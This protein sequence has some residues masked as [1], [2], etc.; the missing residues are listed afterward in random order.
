MTP[1]CTRFLFVNSVTSLVLNAL[2]LC[3]NDLRPTKSEFPEYRS[4]SFDHHGKCQLHPLHG[5]SL[6]PVTVLPWSPLYPD[7]DDT[8][9]E[10]ATQMTKRYLSYDSET[11]S[12]VHAY[13][14]VDNTGT[15]PDISLPHLS[16]RYFLHQPQLPEGGRHS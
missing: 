1:F 9:I 11:R 5:R 12:R 16:A 4:M 13:A 15:V 3:G 7:R 8:D 2:T 14:G 10:V 6:V